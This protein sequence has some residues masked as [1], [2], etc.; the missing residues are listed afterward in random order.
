MFFPSKV[1]PMPRIEV[2]LVWTSCVSVIGRYKLALS[3]R[4]GGAGG[5]AG[6]HCGK[7]SE[8]G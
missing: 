4:G 6:A 8:D 2:A 3:H 5:A 7:A 1:Y